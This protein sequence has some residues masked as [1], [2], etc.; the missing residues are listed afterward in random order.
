MISPYKEKRTKIGRPA[1]LL[2]SVQ[3]LSDC[4][5]ASL[6]I[7]QLM[8]HSWT[9]QSTNWPS[10][11][12]HTPAHLGTCLT[13]KQRWVV[14][15][16]YGP[17][18][19]P[20]LVISIWSPIHFLSRRLSNLVWT[21]GQVCVRQDS[22]YASL[23]LTFWLV[24]WCHQ[25]LFWLVAKP[26]WLQSL[27]GPMFNTFGLTIWPLPFFSFPDRQQAE[28]QGSTNVNKNK[29]WANK[30]RELLYSTRQKNPRIQ[31]HGGLARTAFVK[32]VAGT[33]LRQGSLLRW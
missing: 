26:G 11:S 13:L 22:Q 3:W 17:P 33:L 20:A 18:Q 10:S 15:Q 5:S 24:V 7:D 14:F 32:G 19:P 8:H 9:T 25:R 28:L 12:L 27:R 21:N 4:I 23:N 1:V 31:F 16:S 30:L 6:N 2:I 29:A